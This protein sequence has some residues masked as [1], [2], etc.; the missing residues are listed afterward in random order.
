MC[1]DREV[2]EKCRE[3]LVNERELLDLASNINSF[4]QRTN[5]A[6]LFVKAGD[7]FIYART[8]FS[9]TSDLNK[10]GKAFV[11]GTVPT[12][13]I[14]RIH[15][16]CV[17]GNPQCANHTEPKLFYDFFGL[18]KTP[19]LAGRDPEAILLATE[20]DC[21]PSCNLHSI[22]GIKGLQGMLAM[23]KSDFD[24]DVVEVNFRN[25]DG[26]IGRL[27]RVPKEH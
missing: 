7:D 20:L 8:A 13:R 16:V 11:V 14:N 15:K 21:C 4:P 12:N 2:I 19:E 18:L 26:A 25:S 27:T 6:M 22:N 24:L 17:A 23:T 3:L 10:D 1:K 5:I 9:A